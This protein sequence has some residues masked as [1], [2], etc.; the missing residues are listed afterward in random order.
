MVSLK[1]LLVFLFSLGVFVYTFYVVGTFMLFMSRPRNVSKIY[2]WMFN[3]L[4]NKSRLE[5]SFGPIVYDTLY[6]IGFILQHS[7]MKSALVKSLMEKL[8]LSAADRSIYCLTSS[9]SLHV[10]KC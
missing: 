2:V 5:T 4:D 8:G 6:I 9:L 3:L 10:Y 7:C 1:Q